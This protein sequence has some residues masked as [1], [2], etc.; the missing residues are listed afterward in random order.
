[1]PIREFAEMF[2]LSA[3][4]V[5]ARYLLGI[6]DWQEL[7][8]SPGHTGRPKG[9]IALDDTPD[10]STSELYELYERFAGRSDEREMLAGFAGVPVKEIDD[11]LARFRAKFYGGNHEKVKG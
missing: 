7:G 5:R 9:A 6:R 10:Y 11:V 3:N 2:G 1:M 4:T 8:R